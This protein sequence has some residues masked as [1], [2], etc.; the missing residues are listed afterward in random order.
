MIRESSI[1]LAM[2][3]PITLKMWVRLLGKYVQY[4]TEH[5]TVKLTGPYRYRY[6]QWT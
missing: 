6:R 5:G 2:N 1:D 4:L 3:C